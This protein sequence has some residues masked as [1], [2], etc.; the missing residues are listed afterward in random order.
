M[1]V[2]S[3][4]LA[5]QNSQS[6]NAKAAANKLANGGFE[7]GMKAWNYQQWKGLSIP[8]R[9]SEEKPYEGKKCFVMTS[10][11]D[12]HVRYISSARMAIDAKQNHVISF[13]LAMQDIPKGS[14]HI[15]AL[16]Y[17]P[18]ENKKNKPIGWVYPKRPGMADL[19]P[20]LEGTS[21]WKCYTV[22]IPAAKLAV[23]VSH[24]ALYIQHDQ[25][26]MGELKID[27]VSC[28]VAE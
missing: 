12:T 20:D 27:A 2:C 5:D 10:P 28:S 16:Q 25:P 4:S 15:R 13:A 6:Q 17:G 23:N 19:H 11:G 14:I 9:I 26:S 21:D 22:Q 1:F 24:L 7:D 8:G 3:N 18:D